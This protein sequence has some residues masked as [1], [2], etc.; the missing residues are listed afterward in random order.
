M[1][2][3]QWVMKLAAVDQDL[4]LPHRKEVRVA[5]VHDGEGDWIG[6]LSVYV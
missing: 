4:R 1:Q 3:L 2:Q 5:R 6:F